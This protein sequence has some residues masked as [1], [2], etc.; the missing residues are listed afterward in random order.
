MADVDRVL[1]LLPAIPSES[2]AI[3]TDRGR[4]AKL[5]LLLNLHAQPARTDEHDLK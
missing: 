3:R 1:A 5:A 4:N 2:A